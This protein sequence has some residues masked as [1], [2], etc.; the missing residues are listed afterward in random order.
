MI[1]TRSLLI[2]SVTNKMRNQNQHYRHKKTH[3]RPERKPKKEACVHE[4]FAWG[5]YQLMRYCNDCSTGVSTS[6]FD[7]ESWSVNS[8]IF[9]SVVDWENGEVTRFTEL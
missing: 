7:I 2:F 8:G 6:D 5:K 3:I 4:Y 1:F 9:E